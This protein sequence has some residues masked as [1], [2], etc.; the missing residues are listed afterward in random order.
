MTRTAV[1]PGNE[2]DRRTMGPVPSPDPRRPETRGAKTK[3]KTPFAGNHSQA[4]PVMSAP[5][6][7]ALLAA[8]LLWPQPAFAEP[9]ADAKTPRTD[10]YGDPL[11][12]GAIAR[13]VSI[14]RPTAGS[15]CEDT[16]ALCGEILLAIPSRHRLGLGPRALERVE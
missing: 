9:K 10:R 14:S 6:G 11:P 7:L 5:R 13:L 12:E 4:M 1:G 16:T 2:L 15:S 3:K 8:V